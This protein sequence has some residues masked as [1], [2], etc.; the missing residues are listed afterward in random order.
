MQ[1]KFSYQ[2]VEKKVKEIIIGYLQIDKTVDEIDANEQFF[3][4]K[5]GFNSIDALE[6][7]LEIEQE[8]NIEIAD[9]DLSAEL[10]KSVN[11]IASYV[12]NAVEKE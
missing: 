2:E 7:L 3:L 10:L 1:N 5:F 9:E 8:F 11:L 12:F 6:L 4:D